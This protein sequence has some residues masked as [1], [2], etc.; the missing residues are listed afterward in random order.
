[1]KKRVLIDVRVVADVER[2]IFRPRDMDDH[3]KQAEGLVREFNE[4]V[5]D[6]RSMDWVTL[7]VERD[8]EEQCSH[9]GYVW[10]LDREGVPLCCEKAVAEHTQL[11]PSAWAGL[12]KP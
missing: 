7:N 1:M 2:G 5:R 9:C 8:Y 4:F 10:E 6:H 11:L 3:A 12:A